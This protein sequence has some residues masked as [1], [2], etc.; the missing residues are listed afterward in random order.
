MSCLPRA[1]GVERPTSE[2]A[3]SP[4]TLVVLSPPW[5]R[6]ASAIRGEFNWWEPPAGADVTYRAMFFCCMLD[7]GAT[8]AE[9]Y[10]IAVE[11]DPAN[12]QLAAIM[13]D[14]SSKTD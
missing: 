11:T 4:H 3:K 1:P 7:A 12:E 5:F 6:R 2:L 13:E 14:G 9:G 10:Y 8:T